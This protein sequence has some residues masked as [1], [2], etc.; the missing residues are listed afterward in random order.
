MSAKEE[1]AGTTPH[2]VPRRLGPNHADINAMDG[3]RT[4]AFPTPVM[5]LPAKIAARPPAT[6]V[7]SIPP[8]VM[9]R[10][11]PTTTRVPNREASMPAIRTMTVYPTWFQE[12]SEPATAPLR[13]SDV[14]MDG[15][16]ALYPN[17]PS[18]M[19]ANTATKAMPAMT[20]R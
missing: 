10:P 2:A 19:A 20:N 15:R 9:T 17:L 1:P 5:S 7:S 6:P 16:M 4:I 3:A 14:F 11:V 12:L 13:F 8:A 18:P